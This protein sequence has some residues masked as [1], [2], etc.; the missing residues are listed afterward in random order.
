MNQPI[1]SSRKRW[2][3]WLQLVLSLLAALLVVNLL[4]APLARHVVSDFEFKQVAEQSHSS[5]SLLA[6]T[7][8]DAVITEDIPLL[9]TIAAQSLAQAPD[10]IKLSIKNERDE[11]LVRRVRANAAADENVRT[12][13]YPI[14]LEGERFGTI[15]ID[16]DIEPVQREIDR[17][18]TEVQVFISAMLVLLTGLIVILI[19]VL[20]IRPILRIARYL[21]SLSDRA[22]TES[23]HLPFSASRELTL[24]ATSANQLTSLIQQN[25]QREH[26]LSELV[27]IANRNQAKNTAILS[28]S[29]DAMITIDSEG[30]VV[31][32]NEA[33]VHTFGWSHDEMIGQT[34]ADFIV[35]PDMRDAHRQG[36]EHY[37][38]TGECHLLRKRLQLS[39]LHKHGHRFP[40]E[41]T[42]SPIET[43]Q[44]TMFTAFIRDISE[45]LAAETELRLA[46]QAFESSE[47]MLISNANGDILRVNSAFTDITGYEKHE[48]L[49]QNTR[50]LRSGMH[51]PDLY[52]TMWEQ[53]LERGCWGGEIYNK[54]KN[55]EI[56]P[57]HLN[58]S[59][60][61][62]SE[63]D[64]THYVAH[65]VDISKQKKNEERLRQ[66]HR[67]AEQASLAKSR[68]LAAM[69]H[70]IRTP[71]NGVLGIL[72]LL[73]DTPLNQ[74]QRQLIRTGRESGELLLSI[75]NDILDFSKMEAGKLRLENTHFDLHRLLSHSVEL[76]RPQADN[77]GLEL[78]LYLDRELPRYTRGDPDRLRQI[79][80]NLINNAIKFTSSGQ[81]SLKA[82]ADLDHEDRFTL[83]C[84]V[85]DTGIGIP[86]ETQP[87]LFDEFTMADQ[88][89]SRAHEG[90]GLG[91]A[92]CKRL[93]SLMD[94]SIELVSEPGSGS[95]FYFNVVLEVTDAHAWDN[96]AASDE[97]QRLPAVNTRILLAEDNPAN[98]LVAKSILERAGL[99]VDI[100]A[101]GREA[102]E[103]VR[104]MPYDVVLMDISMPE[105]DGMAATAEI[106]KLSGQAGKV[107]IVALTAHALSG[108]REHFLEGGMD[109]YLTKPINRD[110]TL[111]CIGR[112]TDAKAPAKAEEDIV[113]DT[114]GT[115]FSNG[116]AEYVDEQVLQQLAKDTPPEV[117]PS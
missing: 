49:G 27:A 36:V 73:K 32:Y 91:L 22:P 77:K 29:L 6:A 54:R 66:A 37:L 96:E 52:A 26:E 40:I 56:F 57:E 117:A 82:S 70:E 64:T 110:A 14:E 86:K 113:S 4:T 44:S 34:M 35:P 50:I 17:H 94:G 102:L 15:N 80:L 95:T 83:R 67:E 90:T 20:A 53:L 92:I 89:H 25:K 81:I 43:D 87:S 47:A 8:I 41:I 103:A 62:S 65:F 58:I 108:D 106:R 7:A 93:V 114:P 48:I 39:A 42:I 33:A 105:M 55:G 61:K 21:S 51:D 85:E 84:A 78:N 38:A 11:L 19:H 5:S 16:W 100:A 112:L 75:I 88:S 107:P 12:Y 111:Y 115:L 60:V 74:K 109:D 13:R 104:S 97:S 10:M 99:H 18:V 76:L 59:A 23:L 46:A 28:A 9:D 1:Q 79:L 30:K 69:S 63:G 101:N 45:R 31:D 72:G 116:D 24:L 68:F 3:L 98:Q 71:M 2:P